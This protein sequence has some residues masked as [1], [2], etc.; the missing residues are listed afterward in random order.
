MIENNFSYHIA[1]LPAIPFF[2]CPLKIK[3]NGG[4]C[5]YLLLLPPS[6]KKHCMNFT[7]DDINNA[8]RSLTYQVAFTVVTIG[9]GIAC[10][11]LLLIKH[12]ALKHRLPYAWTGIAL[13]LQ[14]T[15]L[16]LTYEMRTHTPLPSGGVMYAVKHQSAWETIAL[17][18]ILDRP[19]FVLKKELLSIPIFG[20]YLARAD[21]IV[22]D[23]SAGKKA[24]G[25]MIDQ[26]MKYLQA[27]RNI[28]LFPEGTRTQAG[29]AVKYKSGIGAIYEVL[30]PMVYPVGLNS[31]CFWGRN[32]LMRKAGVVEVE[33]LPPLPT[34]LGKAVFMETLHIHIEGATARLVANPRF[35]KGSE[36]Y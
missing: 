29:E 13:T 19:V 30:S 7:Q 31:G 8:C 20:W 3:E 6:L 5:F 22:I 32:R 1:I 35:P 34:G 9:M 25:Q 14:R 26:S 4:F 36:Y 33:I 23:R 11:P 28:V 12:P 15:L 10:L 21:N 17:W 18:H 16:G 24:V 2:F 27:G